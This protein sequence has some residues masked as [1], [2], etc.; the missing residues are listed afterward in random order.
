MSLLKRLTTRNVGTVDRIIR[1]LPTAAFIFVWA[2][3]ALAGTA[4]I[5]FGVIAAM[6]LFTALTSR[7]SVYA[8]FGIGTCPVEKP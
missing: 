7:C 4:L 8:I 5:A 6:L 1:T 2:T 3:G